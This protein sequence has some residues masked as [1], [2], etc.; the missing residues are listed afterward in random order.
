[1][2]SGLNAVGRFQNCTLMTN[3]VFVHAAGKHLPV[4]VSS[5]VQSWLKRMQ[6]TKCQSERQY[7]H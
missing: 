1:M 4:V 5:W 3:L 7:V 6:L 2:V